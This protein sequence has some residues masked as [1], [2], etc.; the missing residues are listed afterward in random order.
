[1]RA[2]TNEPTITSLETCGRTVLKNGSGL[3]ACALTVIER[4]FFSALSALALRAA[5]AGTCSRPRPSNGRH[6]SRGFE[7]ML[8][9]T[10]HQRHRNSSWGAGKA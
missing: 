10:M 2:V 5:S 3:T 9:G 7:G 6:G 1:M 4:H 8:D